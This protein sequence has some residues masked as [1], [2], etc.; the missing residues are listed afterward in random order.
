MTSSEANN[1]AG[2]AK[3]LEYDMP[4]TLRFTCTTFKLKRCGIQYAVSS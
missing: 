4:V 3:M 2:F 1:R